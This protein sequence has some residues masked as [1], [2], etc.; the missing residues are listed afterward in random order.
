MHYI[1][2]TQM[3][4]PSVQR[5]INLSAVFNYLREY[6]PTYKQH[7]S[8]A[9]GISLPSVTRAL[10]A[11][12]ER[13]FAEHTEYRKNKKSRT[14]PYYQITIKENFVIA[15]DVLKGTISGRNLNS[16]FPVEQF[17]IHNT[18]PLIPSLVREI[19][20]FLQNTLEKKAEQI[21]AICIGLPGI[22]DVERGIVNRAIYHPNLESIPIKDEL[23]K[24]FHC[25]VFVDNVVNLAVY[26]NYC[27][28]NRKHENIA[29][30]D[31]GLE[32]GA[33][34]MIN[35]SIY[36]GSNYIAGETG[37]FIDDLTNHDVNYKK[38]CTFRSLAKDM[39]RVGFGPSNY[40]IEDIETNASKC[41]EISEYLFLEVHKGNIKAKD[42]LDT[43]IRRIIL[44]L[45]KIEILLNPER[46]I[47]GGDICCLPSSKEVFLDRL[48]TLYRPIRQMQ[49]P[50]SYSSYGSQVTLEGACQFG[51][52]LYLREEFPYV[53]K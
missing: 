45:N 38:T 48:N 26:A 49:S 50:I 19:H 16:S 37:F 23:E 41:I 32:I 20:I 40:R 7:I 42:I 25:P 43:Y 52:E 34:L 5:A 27:E 21:Q 24:I 10:N 3:A 4:N 1:N 9:L 22:V 12:I 2:L 28:L 6:G 53:F 44:M 29:A 13:G 18:D 39:L 51:L 11:L 33:G 35:G 36:R 15:I 14:V 46:I 47:I 8:R 30:C 17:H 31:I